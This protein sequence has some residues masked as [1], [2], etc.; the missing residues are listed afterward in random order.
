MMFETQQGNH[1]FASPLYSTSKSFA[2]IFKPALT[3]DFYGYDSW[4]AVLPM[5][6]CKVGTAI[7]LPI[8]NMRWLP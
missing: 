2:S 3:V 8:K 4:I 5:F 1:S 6:S 7:F